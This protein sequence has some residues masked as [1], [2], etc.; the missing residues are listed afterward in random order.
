MLD[1]LTLGAATPLSCLAV[2]TLPG[3]SKIGD[4][5][6][7][8]LGQERLLRTS[9]LVPVPRSVEFRDNKAG[10]QHLWGRGVSRP[11][12]HPEMPEQDSGAP[13]DREHGQVAIHPMASWCRVRDSNPRPSVYKYETVRLTKGNAG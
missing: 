12:R 13:P 3:G 7:A 10:R 11:L 6:G 4:P 5:L 9:P 1:S 8:N 2:E